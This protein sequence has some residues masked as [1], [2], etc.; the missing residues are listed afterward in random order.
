MGGFRQ[1]K[2][3]RKENAKKC[4]SEFGHLLHTVQNTIS[5]LRACRAAEIKAKK[6][7]IED[8]AAVR[9]ACWLDH[10]VIVHA[11]HR[12]DTMLGQIV[13][14]ASVWHCNRKSW[15]VTYPVCRGVQSNGKS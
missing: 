2:L 5:H 10:L 4:A 1:R 12:E 3:E 6:Q 7:R 14:A 13:A 15:P 9:C 8:R 11:H